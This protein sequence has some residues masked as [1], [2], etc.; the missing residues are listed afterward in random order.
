MELQNTRL[1]IHMKEYTRQ[2]KVVH[3]NN[4][5]AACVSVLRWPYS[6]CRLGTGTGSVLLIYVT[7][8]LALT[9]MGTQNELGDKGVG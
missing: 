6:L 2:P 8:I 5:L 9:L 7:R 1:N 4:E 3:I